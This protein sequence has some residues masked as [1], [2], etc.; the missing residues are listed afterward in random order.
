VKIWTIRSPAPGVAFSAS[1]GPLGV[2]VLGQFPVWQLDAVRAHE[3]AHLRLG[4]ARAIRRAKRD[5]T[6]DESI[7]RMR[8]H[9]ELDADAHAVRQGHAEGLLAFLWTSRRLDDDD[10]NYPSR[11]ERISNV[12]RVSAEG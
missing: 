7:A 12:I 6:P 11:L 2:I 9:Q 3:E 8:R 4:H 5:G 10:P 1:L